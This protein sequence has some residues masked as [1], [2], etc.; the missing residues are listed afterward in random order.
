MPQLSAKDQVSFDDPAPAAGGRLRIGDGDKV[1]FDDEAPK[2]GKIESFVR[3][4]VQGATLNFSDEMVGALESLFSDKTYAQARDESRAANQAAKDA[5]PWTYGAGELGGGIA[6]SFVPGLG[7]AKGASLGA[8]ALKA[9]AIGA[10][11][12]L[13]ASEKE[14]L[15]GQLQDAATSGA[16]SAATAGIIGKV[17]RGA[18]ERVEKRLIGD[19]TDG[20]TATQRDKV[21][22][23][24]G[25]KA[26][27]V[28]EAIKGNP[29]IKAAKGDPH[30]LLPAIEDAIEREGQR[31][32]GFYPNQQTIKVSDVLG[33]VENVAKKIGNDPGKRD[34]LRAVE[35][36]ANDVLE[37]WGEQTHVTPQQVRVLA[38]DIGDAAFRGSPAVAPKQG[39]TISREVWGELKDLIGEHVDDAMGAGARKELDAANKRMSTLLTMRDAVAYRATR[40]STTP[41]T[42][43]SRLGG[44][45]DLGLA[46]ADPT[47]FAAKKAY[48]FVGKPAARAADEKLAQL[49]VAARNG[50]APAQISQMALEMGLGRG[51]GEALAQWATKRFGAGAQPMPMDEQ[52]PPGP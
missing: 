6:T 20:A 31:L 18:P 3:G 51:T 16:L 37:T 50:S 47:T 49:I 33:R 28:L 39:Q 24:A 34:L 36:K 41:T 10:V 19:I 15:G 46:F 38:K 4:T 7:V 17:V 1:T 35:G 52:P 32:D 5:N 26:G 14:D 42:L 21:V 45:L 29:A 11:S 43:S 2:P 48:D 40:G 8:Q 27:E 25:S 22:G 9:G 44:A 12:G 13:G 23:K 30:Q